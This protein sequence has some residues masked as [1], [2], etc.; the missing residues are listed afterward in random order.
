MNSLNYDEEV[1]MNP[2]KFISKFGEKSMRSKTQKAKKS[3]TY[4]KKSCYFKD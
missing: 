3:L 4:V 1:T 2:P